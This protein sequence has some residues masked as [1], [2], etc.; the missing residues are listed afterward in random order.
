[1]HSHLLQLDLHP[2]RVNLHF[3]G[4]LSRCQDY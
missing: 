4:L 2:G 1:M 3:C